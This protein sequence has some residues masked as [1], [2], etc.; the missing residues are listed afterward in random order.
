MI[1]DFSAR[2]L[3]APVSDTSCCYSKGACPLDDQVLEQSKAIKN[4]YVIA[5]AG[6]P[7][8][9]KTSV[10]NRLTGANQHVA[11]FPGVTVERVEGR[12]RV[13]GKDWVVVDLPGTYSLTAYSIEEIVARNFLAEESPDVVVDI[14]DTSNLQRNLYLATQLLEMGI[15][16]VL[17]ANMQDVAARRGYK[18]D[19]DALTEK[20]GLHVVS[21]EGHLGKGINELKSAINHCITD[22]G[23]LQAKQA[24][25]RFGPELEDDLLQLEN[26]INQ[27]WK[28]DRRLHPPP[29][30]VAV[31]LLE[32]DKHMLNRLPEWNENSDKL[33]LAA[34]DIVS[35]IEEREGVST[36]VYLAGCRHAFIDQL[37]NDCRAELPPPWKR[38]RSDMV[39]N[40]LL[41]RFFGL[42]IFLMFMYL[43]FKFTFTV[44]EIPMEWIENGF[45]WLAAT[46]DTAWPADNLFKSLII[47]GIIGGV[48]GVVI[49]LPNIVMLFFCLSL[50]E[51]TGY[52]SR[53]AFLMDRMM[54]R[55]GLHGK[56][57]IPLLTGFGCS[58]PGIMG[59]RVLENERDRLLT[60]LVLPL[61]SCGA[62]LPI[63]LLIIPAFFPEHLHAR[64]L[65]LIY[66][67][68]VLLAIVS[69][70]LL[71]ISVLK[72]R[73]APF[74]MELPPY[75]I[76]TIRSVVIQLRTRSWL[77][78]RKA[79]TLILGISILLWMLAS[80]PVPN[81]VAND[82]AAQKTQIIVDAGFDPVDF[83]SD[84]FPPEL[85][86]ALIEVDNLQAE[87][88]ME[89][90]LLGRI[91]KAIE[92]IM[93]PMGFDWKISTSMVGAFAAKEIFVAQMGIVFAMGETNEGSAGLR[94]AL[95]ERY[96][97]LIGF[98]VMLFALVAT[99]C[100][101]TFA[102]TKREAGGAKWAWFQ[103]LGLTGMAW[104][105]TVIV[106]QVGSLLGY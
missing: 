73:N 103:L 9:G 96:S 104:I 69:A 52:M 64:M 100:M 79:G 37:M 13:G 83:A 67:I 80:W 1:K 85:K 11:N 2:K 91:G 20:L 42:P 3:Q 86:T 41:N 81:V 90:S 74:V 68:G 8:A 39:D 33:V 58:I 53:A 60:M 84:T 50:M 70:K 16:L 29:R 78:L 45:A 62:R 55:I 71:R 5:L 30:W 34:E 12:A 23:S 92:P 87:A 6:N 54:S 51:D 46:I 18:I 75:K 4:S 10:F 99:P 89:Y 21:L 36:E 14:L 105:L 56:S 27:G 22:A 48:G 66:A 57:F 93:R 94:D 25:V 47:D 101:A 88:E 28:V 35:R 31:R 32:G 102:V 24:Q 38:F 19:L 7:N 49:F 17:A 106:F 44:G 63:Y 77:Y 76:P 61:M 65:F 72:G 98:C 26:L 40:I 15:P 59:T 95:S 43:S 82:F 97:P